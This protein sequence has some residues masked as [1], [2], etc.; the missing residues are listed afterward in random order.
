MT[1]FVTRLEAELHR[2]ALQRE[3]SGR[4]RGVALPRLR[5]ALR[6]VPAAALATVFLGLAVAGVA[7]ILS[8]SPERSANLGMPAELRGVWQAPPKELR[9]YAAGAQ[10]CVNLGLGASQPCYTFGDS[11]TGVAYEWGRLSITGDELTL[12]A[13]QNTTPG[14][15]RWRLRR[16]A[17]GLTKVDDPHAERARALATTPLRPVRSSESRARLPIGW[18]SHPIT[19][20]RFG[21][22]LQ[23]PANWLID[24]SGP[25][26]RFARDPSRDTLPEM[27]VV[28]QDL[29]SGT[30]PARWA[31]VFD[32]RIESACALYDTRRFAFAGTTIRVSVYRGCGDP[33]RQS[34]SFI[35]GG[36]G[37][38]VLWRGR[39]QPSE[40]DYPL[41]DALLKSISFPP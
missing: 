12:H 31:V 22:S 13:T 35:H 21:Y 25:T 30:S 8:A 17:L 14:V 11:S 10:R 39:A 15:Y 19:S 26:D 36:R 20:K 34:A 18:T 23:L 2:A 41:F 29:A 24:T 28:A 9:L 5:V 1:D 32:S 7:L 33:N 37:Y 16:G 6:D 4:V 40:R 3:R 27:S 38:G